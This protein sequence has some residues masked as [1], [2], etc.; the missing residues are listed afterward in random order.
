MACANDHD[1]RVVS[2]FSDWGTSGGG[3]GNGRA[4]RARGRRAFASARHQTRVRTNLPQGLGPAIYVGGKLVYTDGHHILHSRPT[5]STDERLQLPSPVPVR[6]EG[7]D[8]RLVGS[9]HW[10]A[11]A[12]RDQVVFHDLSGVQGKIA[13]PHAV[14][15]QTIANG[16][17]TG[18]VPTDEGLDVFTEEVG[19]ETRRARLRNETRPPV[20]VIGF[21]DAT[22]LV[23]PDGAVYRV[24]SGSVELLAGGQGADY[25]FAYALAYNHHLLLVERTSRHRIRAVSMDGRPP[26][27]EIFTSHPSACAPVLVGD[28]LYL[29]YHDNAAV[30]PYDLLSGQIGTPL[31]TVPGT[32]FLSA[33][34]VT[35]T[36][37][38]RLYVVRRRQQECQVASLNPETG[39]EIVLYNPGGDSLTRLVVA[40]R[41]LAVF[42]RESFVREL[43]MFALFD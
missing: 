40:D 27:P 3:G 25:Q 10:V 20:A 7:E 19:G 24:A 5:D 36:I 2:P 32:E 13:R 42:V 39:G 8:W 14:V 43:R 29:F 33:V 23:M 41:E 31:P 35:G 22:A 30:V 28:L 18:V 37:G 34:A 1:E 15:A 17:W 6:E 4:S 16:V 11:C 38:H 21:S 12:L 26:I 9:G